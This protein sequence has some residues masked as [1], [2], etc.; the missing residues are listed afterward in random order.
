MS[1]A[2]PVLS[3][4]IRDWR[5]QSRSL[6]STEEVVEPDPPRTK[7]DIC[8]SIPVSNGQLVLLIFS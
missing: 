7:R 3:F 6:V 5:E 1:Y 2:N 8:T 4:Y